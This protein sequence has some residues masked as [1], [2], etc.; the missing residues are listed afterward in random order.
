MKRRMKLQP[1]YGAHALVVKG[2]SAGVRVRCLERCYPR[3]GCVA[4]SLSVLPGD[5]PGQW[6]AEVL[7]VDRQLHWIEPRSGRAFHAEAAPAHAL[8]PL[9]E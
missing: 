5:E 6:G 1:T 7:R 8:L 9:Y 2:P 4:K 3:A